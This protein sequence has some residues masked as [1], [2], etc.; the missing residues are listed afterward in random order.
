VATVYAQPGDIAAP[1][2]APEIMSNISALI[3]LCHG[4]AQAAGW[5]TDLRTGEPLERNVGEMLML[6]VSELSEAA[7]GYY[8]SSRD[9]HLPSRTSMEVELGDTL[10]RICDMAGRHN[11][12]LAGAL[13]ELEALPDGADHE[14]RVFLS[15]LRRADNTWIMEYA[16]LRCVCCVSAAMEGHRKNGADLLLPYRRGFEVQ[17]ANTV[18][19]I[20]YLAGALNLDL[21]GAIH[22]KV[23]FNRH[24]PDHKPE[25]RLAPGG[26]DY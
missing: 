20:A 10:I 11:L 21:I 24:R 18:R 26:K 4:A 8:S 9:D 22:D 5:W 25:A 12:N 16:L 1:R 6:T 13:A 3:S 2:P 23:T 14:F 15:I 7:S 17:L 19:H